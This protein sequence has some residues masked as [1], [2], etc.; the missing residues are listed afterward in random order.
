MNVGV[1]YYACGIWDALVLFFLRIIGLSSLLKQTVGKVTEVKQDV[2]S[3][4][5]KRSLVVSAG[6]VG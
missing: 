2:A 3:D 4:V 5:S 6:L 1:Y